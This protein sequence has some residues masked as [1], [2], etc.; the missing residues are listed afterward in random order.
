MFPSH[1]PGKE[2]V[3]AK[4]ASPTDTE[5]VDPAEDSMVYLTDTAVEM[6]DHVEVEALKTRGDIA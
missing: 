2:P 5:G 4:P 1:D 3:M 6:I